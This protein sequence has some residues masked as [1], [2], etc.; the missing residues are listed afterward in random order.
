MNLSTVCIPKKGFPEGWVYIDEV[1]ED[2][3]VDAKYACSEN[4]F[5]KVIDGY[6]QP[7]VVCCKEV[8]EGCKKAADILRPMGYVLKFYDS[9][10]P[11]RAVN[12]FC[13]WGEDVAD[14]RR[15][16][17]HY[18]NVEKKMM[19]EL[20]Y[21]ARRSFHSRGSAVDLTIVDVRTHQELD[22]GSIFDFMDERSHPDFQDLT[23]EQKKNRQLLRETMIACGFDPVD[24]EWWHFNIKNEP[25]PDT[26]FDFPIE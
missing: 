4:V 2:C 12:D 23:Y 25:Y 14:Q 3:I 15:K 6:F 19:F 24:T 8:A 1:I 7:L 18:P 10:R 11:Q 26:Y 21:I 9:Y 5:G 16:P 22:M 13:A 17:V 20:G